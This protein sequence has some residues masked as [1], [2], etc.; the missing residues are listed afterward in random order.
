MI[1]W[2][3]GGRGAQG[4]SRRLDRIGN[5]EGLLQKS[6]STLVEVRWKF[7]DEAL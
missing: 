5:Y 4:V 2:E 1:Q 6:S 3:C 7:S